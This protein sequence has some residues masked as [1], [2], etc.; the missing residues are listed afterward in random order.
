[1]SFGAPTPILRSF[2]ETKAREFYIDFM[3]FEVD[4]EHRFGPDAPL[5]LGVKRGDC[6]LHLSEHHGDCSPGAQ[7]RVPVSA[8]TDFVRGLRDKK[9]KYANPGDPVETPWGLVEV[10]IRDPFGNSLT[11]FEPPP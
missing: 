1:M 5:Y 6:V 10:S 8:L 4:F 9:Y 3:G 11:L 7:V 2:D